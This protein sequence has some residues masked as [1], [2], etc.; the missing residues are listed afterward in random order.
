VALVVSA[1]AGLAAAASLLLPSGGAAQAQALP[2]NT[3]EPQ[4]LGP[5]VVGRT[6]TSTTGTWSGTTPLTFAYQWVRCPKD[7]GRPDG[8]NC[9]VIS[10]GTTSTYVV[11]NADIGFRM[12]V[13]VTAKNSSGSATVASNP[14]GLV[15]SGK[16][17]NTTAPAITGIAAVGETLTASAGVWS[18][19]QPM[20]FGYQW[21]RCSRTGASCSNIGGATANVYVLKSVDAGHT[22]RVRV[23]AQNS[24]GSASATSGATAVVAARPPTGCPPGPLASVS[25]VTPPARLVIDQIQFSPTPVTGSTKTVQ[26]RFHIS[27]TCGQPVADALVYATAVPFNQLSVQEIAS[28]RDGWATIQ[29]HVLAGFPAARHQ[30]LLVVFVRARKP[31]ENLLAGIS[32]RRLVSVHVKL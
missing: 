27:N 28:G 9:G 21:R 17:T 25:Q 20:S 14:T 7:G 30:Q 12:R 1:L 13:R 10:G 19:N 2:V 22:L 29:F 15:S 11:R 24:N 31:G 5:P 4:I 8:S 6:L 32:N 16:P 3:G 18:G 23:I 26:G